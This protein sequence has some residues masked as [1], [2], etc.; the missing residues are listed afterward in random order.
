MRCSECKYDT[1]SFHSVSASFYLHCAKVIN[2]NICEQWKIW[3]DSLQGDLPFF[4][5]LV[6]VTYT[7]CNFLWSLWQQSWHVVS[8]SNA[9]ELIA[10]GFCHHDQPSNECGALSMLRCGCT[11]V[12]WLDIL[13]PWEE[14]TNASYD[15]LS[16]LHPQFEGQAYT[17][18]CFF[19]ECLIAGLQ[20]LWIDL[21]LH[22]AENCLFFI[23][24]SLQRILRCLSLTFCF[25]LRP[26]PWES[27][28]VFFLCSFCRRS[29]FFSFKNQ[30]TVL[31]RSVHC[32]K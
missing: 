30:A 8:S 29:N 19:S 4:P 1:I 22:K 3:A 31:L 15:Q 14:Q 13:H 11:L 17:D 20:L 9:E 21:L 6:A 5:H 28:A 10:C 18:G 24:L 23:I 32:E 25:G 16:R 26:W 2:A 27:E 7:P 12:E